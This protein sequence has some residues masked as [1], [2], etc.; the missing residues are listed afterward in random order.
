MFFN[1]DFYLIKGKLKNKII[2]QSRDFK[3]LERFKIK[4]SNK[5]NNKINFS[6]E[7]K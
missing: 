4:E 7:L 6:R 2:Q 5:I 3:S 1:K